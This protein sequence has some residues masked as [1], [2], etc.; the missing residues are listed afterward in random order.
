MK[1]IATITVLVLFLAMTV[2]TAHQLRHASLVK[3]IPVGN[4]TSFN[5]T[6]RTILQEG[7]DLESII[8][9]E[10]PINITPLD[11]VDG[12]YLILKNN[13]VNVVRL[14]AIYFSYPYNEI[15]DFWV[16][17]DGEVITGSG[18]VITIDTTNFVLNGDTL[19]DNVT[20]TKFFPTT[21]KWKIET[22]IPDFEL[23]EFVFND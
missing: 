10:E 11:I 12:Q 23:I 4:V 5:E 18:G 9:E 21:K 22:N 16:F 20:S 7:Y 8:I 17:L 15:A 13:Q 14:T 3:S 6:N 2:V 19:T 1:K